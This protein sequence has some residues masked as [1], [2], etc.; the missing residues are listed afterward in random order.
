MHL[1]QSYSAVVEWICQLGVI[2]HK[3]LTESKHK[4]QASAGIKYERSMYFCNCLHYSVYIVMVTALSHR[5]DS[6]KLL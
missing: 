6:Y 1:Q 3:H 5:F 4:R 2:Y